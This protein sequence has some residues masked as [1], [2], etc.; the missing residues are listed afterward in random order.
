MLEEWRDIRGYEGFYQ[1]SSLGRVRSL[2]RDITYSNGLV[3]H[4]NGKILSLNRNTNGYLSVLLSKN[5]EKK[6]V[7]IHRL[8][9]E[10]FIE[11]PNNF[12]E[13]NHKNED[14]ND[15]CVENLEWC[16]RKYNVNYGNHK[17]KQIASR[18]TPI[19]QL[20]VDGDY[21]N[22]YPSAHEA[23]RALGNESY[24]GSISKANRGDAYIAYGFCWCSV[25][26]YEKY[27]KGQS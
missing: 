6:R 17:T 13:V 22:T 18:G 26:Q 1:V 15:N 3:V 16:D 9:A 4:Y 21:V 20:T 5:N 27:F 10:A 19:V 11:N 12:L 7:M 24:Q 23:A 2:D 25:E 14:K 8:V